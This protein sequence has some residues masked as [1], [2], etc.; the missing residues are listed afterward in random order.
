MVL[1]GGRSILKMVLDLQELVDN[2][3]AYVVVDC[4]EEDNM[5]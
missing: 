1:T 2:I 5:V 4:A 3:I